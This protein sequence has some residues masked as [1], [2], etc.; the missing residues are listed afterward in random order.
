MPNQVKKPPSACS[1][2]QE[3]GVEPHKKKR[4]GE[5]GPKPDENSVALLSPVAVAQ[6]EVAKKIP[7]TS[8][9][10]QPKPRLR[11]KKSCVSRAA[12]MAWDFAARAVLVLLFVC[13]CVSIVPSYDPVSLFTNR[14]TSKLPYSVSVPIVSFF[15]VSVLLMLLRFCDGKRKK[16]HPRSAEAIEKAHKERESSSIIQVKQILQP[17]TELI[18]TTLSPLLTSNYSYPIPCCSYSTLSTTIYRLDCTA[19]L[20]QLPTATV[21]Q[22]PTTL[23]PTTLP[24]KV[25]DNGDMVEELFT[26]AQG[27]EPEDTAPHPV[28]RAASDLMFAIT[29]IK[30]LLE[31]FPQF[32]FKIRF[33]ETKK[34]LLFRDSSS[35]FSDLLIIF[36]CVLN[37]SCATN[38]FLQLISRAS[39]P[40]VSGCDQKK[41]GAS[42]SVPTLV[43]LML[44]VIL[45]WACYA[46]VFIESDVTTS[47]MWVY[48]QVASLVGPMVMT[49][50]LIA[51]ARRWHQWRDAGV[52]PWLKLIPILPVADCKLTQRIKHPDAYT[53]PEKPAWK[54]PTF[55]RNL[56]Q[57]INPQGPSSLEEFFLTLYC[58][59]IW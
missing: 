13:L 33:L 1:L 38:V 20:H 39:L 50:P 12:A 49:L 52:S 43:P 4:K 55:Q 11:K 48:L 10:G 19:N 21:S 36:S 44:A 32:L 59:L 16:A 15:G 47:S 22:L 54:P 6:Q 51:V 9:N 35:A 26:A 27:D 14:M 2:E 57:L 53:P 41:R 18:P 3:L 30:S 5:D 56:S 7:P 40:L 46:L 37:F 31:D 28:R 17:P 23:L 34:D 25:A 42:G 45:D 8:K 29:L 58:G 24:Q